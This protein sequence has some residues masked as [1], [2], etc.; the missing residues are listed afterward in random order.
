MPII[1]KRSNVQIAGLIVLTSGVVLSAGCVKKSEYEALEA[2]YNEALSTQ[3][4]LVE[5]VEMQD[6][7]ISE[8]EDD[9]VVLTEI[10]AEEIENQALQ[11]EQ[12]VDGIEVEI[13]SDVMFKSGSPRPEVGSEGLEY[14]AKLAGFLAEND[15][16]VSV[17]GHTDNQKVSPKLAKKYPSNWHLAGARAAGAAKYLV[18]K[19]VDPTQLVASSRGQY[20]P[21]ASNKT[22]EGRAQNRRIQIILRDLP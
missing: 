14:V 21:V 20:A 9:F 5:T 12:L 3:G 22:R 17:I 11:L 8:L 15:Y 13:P 2:K 19:G 18:S 6:A 16:F 4:E 1:M 7:A 10:F